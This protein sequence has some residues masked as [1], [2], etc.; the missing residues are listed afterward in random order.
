MMSLPPRSIP[1][2]LTAL[3]LVLC[4]PALA[5]AGSWT[6]EF[7]SRK[8]PSLSYLEDGKTAFLLG[9]GRAFGLHAKYPG[10]AKRSGKVT[11]TISNAR[12]RMKLHGEFEEPD[13][14]D[15][16]TF[17]QWDLGFSRQDPR[18]Y[19]KRWGQIQSRLLDLLEHADPLIISQGP[20]SYRLPRIDAA[21]W[22]IAIEKC[23]G[24]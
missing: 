12:G 3:L 17:V 19:G 10:T 20:S 24:D 14:A 11:V 22:R 16:T 2:L 6:L 5:A 1:T 7:D 13:A 23:G 4:A 8:L 9:C 18:L 15:Q 21:N